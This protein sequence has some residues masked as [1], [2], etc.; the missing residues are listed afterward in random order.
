MSDYEYVPNEDSPAVEP[1]VA[2]HG[3]EQQG[4]GFV[5]RD[6]DTLRIDSD[7]IAEL[8]R[9]WAQLVLRDDTIRTLKTEVDTLRFSQIDGSDSRLTDFWA[10]AQELAERANHCEIFDEIAEAL[11][12]PRRTR[13]YSVTISAYATVP[14]T[15]TIAVEA[16]DTEE[17]EE[18]AMNEISGYSNWN[19]QQNADWDSAE[20][21][22]DSMT[23]EVE[24]A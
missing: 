2:P 15:V 18:Y 20:L 8:N 6:A 5:F 24:E 16:R 9:I 23:C 12:G 22:D 11:G 4:T 10:R 7:P 3:Y 19:L 14:V 17:A 13:E 21:D 1:P